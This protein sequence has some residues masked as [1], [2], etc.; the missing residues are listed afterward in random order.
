MSFQ[1]TFYI[2]I[3]SLHQW[4]HCG[5]H[6]S[7]PPT[8]FI[9]LPPS[10]MHHCKTTPLAAMPPENSPQ[11]ALSPI[12]LQHLHWAPLLHSSWSLFQ[13]FLLCFQ[14]FSWTCKLSI[15]YNT[16][17]LTR[18]AQLMVQAALKYEVS[19]SGSGSYSSRFCLQTL[20]KSDLIASLILL[21]EFLRVFWSPDTA[22]PPIPGRNDA[23]CF[24]DHAA[25]SAVLCIAF[26]FV[27]PPLANWSNRTALHLV[28][29]LVNCLGI[30]PFQSVPTDPPSYC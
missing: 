28:N 29:C 8:M 16:L 6:H 11:V 20:T 23:L 3:L 15:L 27:S 22:T 18:I 2:D 7:I 4:Y 17:N 12:C 19:I 25:C 13:R 24:L 1:S 5:S 10:K 14:C 9:S 26:Q 21:M 30:L